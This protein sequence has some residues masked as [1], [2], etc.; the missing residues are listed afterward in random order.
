MTKRTFTSFGAVALATILAGCGGGGGGG[1]LP[2][3]GSGSSGNGSAS[4]QSETAI[5]ATNALGS[6]L[7]GI[8]DDNGASSQQAQGAIE[9]IASNGACANYT[10]FFSPDK[11]GD[12][13]STET[14]L[15]YDAA[16]TQT[17]RDAVRTFASTG[18]TSETVQRTVKMYAQGNGTPIATRSEATTIGN[19][20]FD[21]NG[22]PKVA[23]GFDRVVVGSLDLAGIKTI[24]EDHEQVVLPQSG[25][26]NTYCSDSAGFNA[27]GI[28]N[29]NETFGWN[30]GTSGSATRTVNGDGTVTWS[31]THAG[32]DYKGAIG[33]LSIGTGTQ[34]VACPIVT[35]MFTLSGGA[36]TGSYSIPV[37]A[38]Y[39]GAILVNLTI[40]NAQLA[41][42]STLNVVTNA[43]VPPT[44]VGFITGA[45][46]NAGSQTATFQVDAFGDGTLTV[47]ASGVQY[48]INDWHVVK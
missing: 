2:G 13:N 25:S 16:C 42:G 17:A 43:G 46:S 36:S 45:I 47:T 41:N 31:A 1:V 7:K 27:T 5:A 12:P 6:P 8:A 38:T 29:L 21:S 39:K 35:P 20:T 14:I 23:T 32:A 28:A 33:A 37:V 11:A 3:G 4:S 48:V 40:T 24:D 44:T 30:G 22:F 15:F 26:V 19:A 34:N 9:G 18:A 10:E